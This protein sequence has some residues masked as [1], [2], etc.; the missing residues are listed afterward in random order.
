M[1]RVVILSNLDECCGN[2]TYGR[3]LRSHLAQWYD[4]Q[5]LDAGQWNAN[6]G[7]PHVVIINWHPA[8]VSTHVGHVESLQ[9]NGAKVI[10]ILQNSFDETHNV[11]SRDLLAVCDAVVAHEPMKVFYDGKAAHNVH[12]IPHGILEVP[13]LHQ[14]NASVVS[15]F[16]TAG[17]QFPWKRPE[18]VVEAARRCGVFAR[19]YCPPYPGFDRN[20]E[21]DKW[22]LMYKN[23]HVDRNW[24]PEGQVIQGLSEHLLN[25]FWFQ[26]RGTDDTFGQTGSAR[27]GVAAK[28]PMIISRHRKFRTFMDYEE[29]FYIADTEEEVYAFSREIMDNPSSARRPNR[30]V[31]ETGW[32]K[33]AELYHNLIESL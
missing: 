29:E 1:R 19:I 15:M 30:I 4:V 25:I 7:K 6:A 13:N 3:L 21:I 26:S 24:L 12:F 22:N 20:R 32:S 31:A 9:E 5:M 11:T 2:A 17:F 18:V 16:G 33:T 10:L 23:V 8:K 28:R 27:M 14:W